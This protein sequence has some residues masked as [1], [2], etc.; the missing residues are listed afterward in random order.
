MV[1]TITG[2]STPFSSQDPV[3]EELKGIRSALDQLNENLAR[4]V[5]QR[6]KL[7]TGSNQNGQN[8]VN[9]EKLLTIELPENPTNEQVKTYIEQIKAAT[10]G[11]RSISSNDPQVAMYVA[12]G[13]EYLPE[14]VDALPVGSSYSQ[15]TY[16]ILPAIEQ[17]MMDEGDK[18]LILKSLAK[19]P[20]LIRIINNKNWAEDAHDTLVEGLKSGERLSTDWVRAVAALRDPETYPLL[21]EY[22]ISG[23]NRSWTYEAIKDLPIEDMEDAVNEAWTAGKYEHEYERHRLADI[24]VTYGNKEALE[25]LIHALKFPSS[26]SAAARLNSTSRFIILG[27]IDF[28]GSNEELWNWFEAN[29]DQIEFNA[30]T[31][32]FVLQGESKYV[33]DK[34]PA[35]E[36]AASAKKDSVK[37]EVEKGPGGRVAVWMDDVEQA[38]AEAAKYDMPILLL[39][40]APSWCGYCRKLDDQFIAQDEFKAYA[41]KHLVLL[42]SDHSDKAKGDLWKEN[43]SEL[44]EACPIKGF[45]HMYLLTP[46]AEKLGSIAYYE[47]EWSIQDYLDKIEALKDGN[48]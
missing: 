22:F 21:R 18:E 27:L 35:V 42:I 32:R 11:Q 29:K 48:S 2:C 26:N 12:V 30:E 38:K 44:V 25:Y 5:E 10:E 1:G 33:A 39:Y 8:K 6:A 43:N 45:P 13:K 4:Q 16:H 14:L 3:V 37:S 28:R 40:T 31:R 23:D 7:L 9:V 34:A 20:R 24:V 46:D 19:H 36:E 17:L 41:N 15:S 47:P